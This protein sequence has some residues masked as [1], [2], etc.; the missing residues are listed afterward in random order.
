MNIKKL[1]AIFLIMLTPML[2]CI[3]VCASENSMRGVWV[4]TV[5]GLDF[6]SAATTDSTR[7]KSD[8]D[9]I[10]TNVKDAGFNTIFLQV[11]PGADSF[12]PSVIFPWSKYLTGKSGLAPSNGF[13]PLKYWVDACH[14]NS[15]EIHA[16]INPYRVT[17]GSDAELNALC[18]DHPAK[19]HPEWLVKYKDGNYY[20]NPGIP[21]VQDLVYNGVAEILQ[22]YDVDGLHMD[23]YFYPGADFNDNATYNKYNNGRFSNIA[24]WRRNNVNELVKSLHNLSRLYG[25]EFGISP[26]GIWDNLK[27]NAL[28]SNTRGRSSYSELFADSRAWVKNGYVDYIAPQVYWEFGYEIADYGIVTKWWQD[29]CDGTNV[30][31][32]IGLATY[33]ASEVGSD[34]VWYGGKE[35]LKQMQYN[36]SQSNIDGE[37][38]FRYKLIFGTPGISDVVKN[39]YAQNTSTVPPEPNPPLDIEPPYVPP[40]DGLPET[41]PPEIGSTPSEITVYV[42][43]KKILFDTPPIIENDRTLV[44]MRAV[45]EALG[46]VVNWDQATNT[47]IANRDGVEMRVQPGSYILRLGEER[48]LLDVPAKIVNNRTLM[49]LRAISEAFGYQ[50]NWDG[51]TRTVTI[52]G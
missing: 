12:Y 27:D 32:Y 4:S 13:D 50:V 18:A 20:F 44:P 1:I 41:N 30:K 22:N 31:L 43:G 15:L 8:I 47:A 49:P 5:Y 36:H 46:A 48:H 16:W 35:T 6:P 33:R 17:K 9:A 42:N 10:I 38:H 11:R 39:F 24:D 45:F 21:D 52:N 7:L 29:V 37:I 14:N 2:T 25:T 51:I 26:S 23:D 34:S 28:G 40:A 3:G 19:L